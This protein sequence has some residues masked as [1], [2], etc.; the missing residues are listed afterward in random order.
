VS[1]TR[2]GGRNAAATNKKRHGEDFYARIGSLG[3]K[4]GRTGGFYGD[5]ERARAIGAQGG[6][7]SKIGYRAYKQSDGT[8]KYVKKEK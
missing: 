2:A 5:K 6:K 8:Y 4:N 3:G 1:G 7:V